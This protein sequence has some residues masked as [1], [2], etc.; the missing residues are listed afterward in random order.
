MNGRL[1][2]LVVF[3]FLTSVASAAV[4]TVSDLPPSPYADTEASSNVVFNET[5]GEGQMDNV[6]WRM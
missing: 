4:R 3:L 5:R 6:K 1:G 2:L